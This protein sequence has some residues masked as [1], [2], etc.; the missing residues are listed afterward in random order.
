MFSQTKA[1]K[2]VE[3]RGPRWAIYGQIR[4]GE[5]RTEYADTAE[6]AEKIRADFEDPRTCNYRQVTVHPPAGS[7]NLEALARDRSRAQAA[8]TEATAV[9]RPAVLR[10]PQGEPR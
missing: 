2:R 6:K 3:Q 5:A 4:S 7:G 9:L 10:R 8:L 1:L